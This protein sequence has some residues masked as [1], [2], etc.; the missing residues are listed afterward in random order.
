MSYVTCRLRL[1]YLDQVQ[2]TREGCGRGLM[3]A[4]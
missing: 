3:V 2:V 1:A 4:T